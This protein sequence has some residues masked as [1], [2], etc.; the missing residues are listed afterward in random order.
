M[1]GRARHIG[2]ELTLLTPESGGLELRIDLPLD[3]SNAA[4]LSLAA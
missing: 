1:L 2:A 3:E 4:S